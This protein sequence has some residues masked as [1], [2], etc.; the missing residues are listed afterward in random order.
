MQENVTIYLTY[1]ED[2]I[3]FKVILNY[4]KPNICVI[5]VSDLIC[6]EALAV[7]HWKKTSDNSAQELFTQLREIFEY[8]AK[9]FA[10]SAV[11]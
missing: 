5:C 8:G 1:F 4:A 3:S 9:L 2:K 10:L 7:K 11:W 6:S